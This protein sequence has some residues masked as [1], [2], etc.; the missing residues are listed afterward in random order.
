MFVEARKMYGEEKLDDV[1]ASLY[2]Q[3]AKSR[4]ASTEAFLQEVENK[5][6]AQPR[7]WF[8]TV[9]TNPEWASLE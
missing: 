3:F 9:L 2:H 6:G 4:S 5:L 7:A 1:L 8:V